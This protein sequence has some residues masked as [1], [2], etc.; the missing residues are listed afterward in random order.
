MCVGKNET[1]TTTGARRRRRSIMCWQRS[2]EE[3]NKYMARRAGI[4]KNKNRKAML[5]SA[6]HGRRE[7]DKLCVCVRQRERERM[8]ESMQHKATISPS[9]G[10]VSSRG[11]DG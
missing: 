1:N 8:S 7:R 4:G 3:M 2:Q 9:D 5:F 10:G 6:I 11:G